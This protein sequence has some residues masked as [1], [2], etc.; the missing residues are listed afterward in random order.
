LAFWGSSNG[1]FFPRYTYVQRARDELDVF[2]MGQDDSGCIQVDNITDLALADY[3]AAYGPEVSK[4]DIFFYVYGLLHSPDYRVAFADDLK[5]VLPRIP[6][7]PGEGDFEAF[8]A[9]GRRLADL[10]IGYETVEPFPLDVTGLPEPALTGKP[11]YDW[12]RVEKMRFAGNARAKDRSAVIYNERIT[13]AGI[14]DQ[15]HEYTLGARSAIE[16]IIERYRVKTDKA[17]GIVNDPN[18]WARE[19]EQPRYILDLLA[20][21]VTVSVKTVEIVRSLPALCLTI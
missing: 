18:D 13:V 4:D 12:Y 6:M 3:Q 15:A 21:V 20:R 8:M 17:S 9:A 7:V 16:W 14:P 2:D 5:K 1:Q 10:H 19:H 11:L